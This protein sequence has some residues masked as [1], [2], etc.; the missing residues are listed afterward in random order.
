M[1]PSSSKEHF[2][3][4]SF[5]F[6]ALAIPIEATVSHLQF[7]RDPTQAAL[8]GWLDRMGFV[9]PGVPDSVREL[10]PSPILTLTDDSVLLIFQVF[11]IYLAGAAILFGLWAEYKREQTPLLSAGLMFGSLA[12]LL[13]S[14]GWGL[15]AMV[16]CAAAVTALRLRTG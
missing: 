6:G 16:A 8:L 5:I 14:A 2:G 9:R 1:N 10:K 11:G 12:L 7:T 3:F 15:F 4:C 13:V